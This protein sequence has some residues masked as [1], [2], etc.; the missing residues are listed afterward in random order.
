MTIDLAVSLAALF[1][2][3]FSLGWAVCNHMWIKRMER[4]DQP[5]GSAD[6]AK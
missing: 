2:A 4:P 3:G 1:V 6:A 5:S